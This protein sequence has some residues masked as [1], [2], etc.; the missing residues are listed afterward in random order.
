MALM[1]ETRTVTIHLSDPVYAGLVERGRKAGYT[2]T[3]YAKLL[4]EAAYAARV[5][6]GESDPM[7]DACVG[8]SLDRR[9][10]AVPM[11]STASAPI[12]ETRVIHEPVAVPVIVPVILPM[13]I[14]VPVREDGAVERLDVHVTGSQPITD[15]AAGHL[16]TLIGAAVAKHQTCLRDLRFDHGMQGP[17][18]AGQCTW[19]DCVDAEPTRSPS[20]A[21]RALD[22][23]IRAL[24][25]AGN[26]R[27]EIM[28][29]LDCT[30]ADVLEALGSDA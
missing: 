2:P 15:E 22:R 4:F 8:K 28:E 21:R 20:R 5:G 13:P 12:V 10:A 6:K 14:P 1:P 25:A 18:S 24:A 23:S 26:D 7:L 17:C 29:A 3:L 30:S 9:P 19:P 16:A 27:N 11:P